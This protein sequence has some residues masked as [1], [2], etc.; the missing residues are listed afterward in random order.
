MKNPV[1]PSGPRV[2]VSNVGVPQSLLATNAPG[3]ANSEGVKRVDLV[4][5]D[6]KIGAILPAG[7]TAVGAVF[8]ADNG[9]AWPTFADLHTHLDKGHIIL[10]AA[11]CDGT[12]DTARTQ[13]RADTVSK[14]KAHDVEARFE[15]ALRTAYAHGTSAIRTHIDCF[16]T[17]QAPVSLN[18]FR[19][20]RERWA[21]RIELQAAALVS[22]DLYQDPANASLIDV[23]AD[24]GGKLGG[25]VY[26][27]FESDDPAVLDGR[28][29]HLFALA[30]SRG[31]D[32]DLHV[33]ENG[34]PAST[35]LA[36]IAA[37]VLRTGFKGHVV[38]GH[39]CSLSVIDEKIA[40]RT[41]QLVKEAGI[42]IVSL[43]LVN[44]YLQGRRPG[45][46]P[47]W[48]GI[49]L[50]R[51]LQSAGVTVVLASDNCRDPYHAF[52]DHDL[53][54][55]LGGGIRIGHLDAEIDKWTASVTR[56]PLH[57]MGLTEAGVLCPGTAAD[58]VI[59]RGR[60]YSEI[61]ARRQGDRVVIRQGKAIDTTPPDFRSLDHLMG[62]S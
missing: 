13:T 53:L 12:L 60:T 23:I 9:Q 62:K 10:R 56:N 30:A 20:L 40:I 39:C 33:D 50:L 5:D 21:G 17:A 2:H 49:P 11:N 22:P 58:L 3:V 52:G 19:H 32:V 51:E 47:R 34:S 45:A 48:R 35:T 31:L 4:V 41:I 55:V 27:L 38:C 15:F 28:L 61:F 57:A 36:Q 29:E 24:A 44:Q 7:S 16:V 26:R 46:T 18:V 8:D 37:T 54:E 1:W 59:Y 42:T 43:P 6:G 25:I 14:W